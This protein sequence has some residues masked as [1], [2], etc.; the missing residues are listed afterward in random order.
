[1][2]NISYRIVNNIIIRLPTPE[3]ENEKQNSSWDLLKNAAPVVATASAVVGVIYIAS[4]LFSGNSGFIQ[5]GYNMWV[6][7]IG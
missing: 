7:A 4:G 3:T 6:D 1:M 2:Y 5:S